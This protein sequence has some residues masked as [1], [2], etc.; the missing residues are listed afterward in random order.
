MYFS[1]VF[2]KT[3]FLLFTKKFRTLMCVIQLLAAYIHSGMGLREICVTN[4]IPK[5]LEDALK[6]ASFSHLGIF[7]LGIIALG[8]KLIYPCA[9]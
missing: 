1:L 4:Y 8:G 9:Q 5:L 6:H 3:S 2:I 7:A